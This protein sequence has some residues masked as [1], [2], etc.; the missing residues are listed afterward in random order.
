MGKVKRS[1]GNKSKRS[2]AITALDKECR[3]RFGISLEQY[4]R[5]LDEADAEIER[6]EFTSHEEVM[7]QV[8][9]W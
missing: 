4:N 6:G 7:K 8:K 9:D 5:E 2:A 1:T 3:E